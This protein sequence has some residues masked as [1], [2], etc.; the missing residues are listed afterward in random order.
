MEE[1][2]VRDEAHTNGL[3][4]PKLEDGVAEEV[5]DRLGSRLVVLKHGRRGQSDPVLE[6]L[7][8][9]GQEPGSAEVVNFVG[10]E[11][12]P[13]R[14]GNRV[15]HLREGIAQKIVVCHDRNLDVPDLTIKSANGFA[16]SRVPI[17]AAKVSQAERGDAEEA[18]LLSPLLYKGAVR[19][20][21][22]YE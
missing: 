6:L 11:Q 2:V 4:K 7:R 9:V 1:I 19:R 15:Q 18:S 21:D 14:R 8:R 20:G 22:E 13:D 12:G 5:R 3:G 17:G 16:D 10:D